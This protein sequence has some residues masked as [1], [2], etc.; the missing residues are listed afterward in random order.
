MT[1]KKTSATR[2]YELCDTG[3]SCS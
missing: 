1:T 3:W 2:S